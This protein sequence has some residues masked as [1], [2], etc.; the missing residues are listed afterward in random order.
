MAH[1]NLD[2]GNLAACPVCFRVLEADGATLPIKEE[3]DHT[4]V[5]YGSCRGCTQCY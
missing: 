1:I 2:I 4:R 5:E 3:Y